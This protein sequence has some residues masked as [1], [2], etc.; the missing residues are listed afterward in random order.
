MPHRSVPERYAGRTLHGYRALRKLHFLR[1]GVTAVYVGFRY[2]HRLA[3]K[4]F[5]LR[6]LLGREDGL[7]TS[8][9]AI[10]SIDNLAKFL[11]MSNWS[12]T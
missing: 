1:S 10:D 3:D 11:R 5:A 8:E 6:V 2:H 9:G 4:P 7:D 12:K